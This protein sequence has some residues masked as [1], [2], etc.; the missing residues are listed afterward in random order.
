MTRRKVEPLPAAVQRVLDWAARAWAREQ[1]FGSRDP[2]GGPLRR[3]D[4]RLARIGEHA[5]GLLEALGEGEDPGPS[6][7]G[8]FGDALPV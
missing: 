7:E 1:H 6:T 5:N 3:R 4:E 2:V 8:F